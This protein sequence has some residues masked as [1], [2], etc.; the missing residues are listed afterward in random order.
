MTS[1]QQEA[2]EFGG[3]MVPPA[4]P[5][6]INDNASAADAASRVDADGDSDFPG[7]NPDEIQPDQ[8][9]FDQPG[10]SPEQEVPGQG[11]DIDRPGQNPAETPAQPAV[12]KESP[13]PG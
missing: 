2:V 10:R 1:E 7:S 12:P 6:V 3:R 9:D 13:P 11:G 8:G 4:T 5:P